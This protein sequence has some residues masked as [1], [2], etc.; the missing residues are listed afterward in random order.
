MKSTPA[1]VPLNPLPGIV[2]AALP[3][4]EQ[5]RVAKL[6][7]YRVLDT[8][9]EATYD[10]LTSLAAYICETE[11]ALIS[12]VDV[13]RQWFKS[14]Q[15]LAISE[16]PRDFAFCAHTILQAEVMVVTD[17]AK[18]PRFARNPLVMGDPHIRFYAG[19]PL[20]TTEGYALGTI[21]V[22]DSKPRQLKPEQITALAALARQVVSQLDQRL[23]IQSI[24]ETLDQLQQAQGQLVHAERIA[25]L[26]QMVAGV[27]HEI[28]NPLGFINGSIDLARQYGADLI[29]LLQL[30]RNKY[31]EQDQEIAQTIKAVDLDFITED[32]VDMLDAMQVGT[33]RMTEIVRSL[34]NFSRSGRQG[35]D[36]ADIHAGIDST[37]LL[38]RHRLKM[39]G[40]AQQPVTVTKHYGDIPKI[41]CNLSQLNQVF[42]NLLAN[43]LDALGEAVDCLATA[44][45]A[46]WIETQ[47]ADRHVLITIR[48]NGP[49]MSPAQVEK[50]FDPFFTTKPADQGTGLGLSI[51]RQVVTQKHGGELICQSQPGVGTT[52][53][54]KIPNDL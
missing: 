2:P 16:T 7:S 14:R 52:F 36:P 25:A 53:T 33:T 43:A 20:I 3:V 29:E 49:G 21:C 38:L 23:A 27:A 17:A 50:I 4:N 19:A 5:E 31:G 51:S 41:R 24:D 9:A 37:L 39:I 47:A 42:M 46:I 40:K 35:F 28:N 54:L 10:D 15:G 11:T 45:P 44:E 34:R 8:Q 26:G 22:L 48:D 1:D 32:L 12:L 18:D 30:Y 6:L 13:S